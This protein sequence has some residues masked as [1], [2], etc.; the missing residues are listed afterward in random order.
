MVGVPQEALDAMAVFNTELAKR[1]EQPINKAK[2]VF[3]ATCKE[4]GLKHGADV[5]RRH[6][7]A[8]AVHIRRLVE[9]ADEP[10]TQANAQEERELLE[11][12][13]LM[14]HPDIDGLTQA[15]RDRRERNG[16]AK[17]GKRRL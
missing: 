1:G 2:T 8:L 17:S 4:S 14:H 6:V 13:R 16:N 11:K 12:C 9:L 15:L 10:A 5:N 3:C 7:T